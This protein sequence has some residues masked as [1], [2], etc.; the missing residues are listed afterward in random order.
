ECLV[1]DAVDV[2]DVGARAALQ[3]Y[4]VGI[5][6][7]EV[8]RDAAGKALHRT[9]MQSRRLRRPVQQYLVLPIG[10]LRRTRVQTV[11]VHAYHLL[12]WREPTGPDRAQ[13]TAATAGSS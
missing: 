3:V 1:G 9:L 2:P 5:M 13:A 11:D 7:L 10:D 4:G 6:S 12:R 8:R